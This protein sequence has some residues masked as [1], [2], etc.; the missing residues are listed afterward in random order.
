M[1][2]NEL[3]EGFMSN[4]EL[5]NWF[6]ITE[7]GFSKRKSKILPRLSDYCDYKAVRGGAMIS[8]IKLSTYVK[9]K[10][11]KIVY[12][13]YRDC[14]SEDGLDTCTHVGN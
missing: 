2:T 14:W 4:Q 9:N 8:N 12:D 11:F 13:N 1:E 6:E 7:N 3:H 10:N 5:A